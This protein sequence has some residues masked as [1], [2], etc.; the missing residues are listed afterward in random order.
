MDDSIISVLMECE[1]EVIMSC[2]NMNDV[3]YQ[4]VNPNFLL[5]KLT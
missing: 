4:H 5:R 2:E 3:N 1:V